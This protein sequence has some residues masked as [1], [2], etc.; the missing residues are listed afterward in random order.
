VLTAESVEKTVKQP[1]QE[2]LTKLRRCYAQIDA[3]VRDAQ[4]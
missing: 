1:S 3:D 2:E 4:T